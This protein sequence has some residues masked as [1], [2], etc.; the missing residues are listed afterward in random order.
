MIRNDR[1]GFQVVKQS[2][3]LTS[4]SA[5]GRLI[6]ALS[7]KGHY[8]QTHALTKVVS[9]LIHCVVRQ[10]IFLVKNNELPT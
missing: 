9:K 6:I 2:E 4:P 8:Y 10:G 7:Q 3:V 5:I 1:Y